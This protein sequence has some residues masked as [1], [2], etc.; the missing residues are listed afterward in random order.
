MRTGCGFFAILSFA[1]SAGAQ[2]VPPW[3]ARGSLP[4]GDDARSVEIRRNDE[5]LFTLANP[6]AARRGAAALGARL[7]LYGAVAGPGCRSD[8]LLVGPTAWVCGDVVRI[9]SEP[10][11]GASVARARTADGL[12]RA[13]YFVG[14]DGALG[15][16]ALGAAGDSAP[17]AELQPGYAISIAA[18]G[19]GPRGDPFGLTSKGFWL[20]M[21]DLRPARPTVFQGYEPSHGL[22]DRGWVV[23]DSATVYSEPGR[24]RT[25]PGAKRR[26]DLV[27]LLERRD[28]KGRQWV[29]I[30]DATWLDAS[31][32]RAPT[33][34]EPPLEARDGERWLDVDLAAQVVTAYEGRTPVFTTLASTGMGKGR[35]PTATPL[36]V[37][38]IWVKLLTSDMDNLEDVEARKYYAMLDVPWVLFFEKGFG[39]HGAF[40]HSSFGHVRSHGCVNLTPLDAERLFDWASPHLPAGWTAVLPTDYDRGTLVRVR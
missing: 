14:P 25:E 38:R 28:A 12:P 15:Y 2:G 22:L 26:F 1:G 27:P 39:V 5:P 4:L 34:S 7:P 37:H 35:E 32:V 13:Y 18:T 10:P 30:A 40:W 20:P 11:L 9:S 33:P 21:T 23:A 3:V 24:K 16:G 31:D 6:T 19:S 29:R 17:V 36:G 8:W